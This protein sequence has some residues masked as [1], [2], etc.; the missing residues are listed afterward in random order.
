MGLS[1]VY[2]KPAFLSGEMDG[3]DVNCAIHFYRKIMGEIDFLSFRS[4]E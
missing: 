4:E 3:K 1:S 2:S